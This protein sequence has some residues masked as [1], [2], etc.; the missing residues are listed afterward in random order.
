MKFL[1][2]T[3]LQHFYDKYLRPLKD[4]AFKNTANNLT[5]ETEGSVLDARQGKV[6]NDLKLSIAKVINNLLTTEAGFALDARQ[7]KVLDDKITELN[8]NKIDTYNISINTGE[9]LTGETFVGRP[10]YEKLVDIGALPNKTQKTVP[11]GISNAH[12]FWIDPTYSMIFNTAASYPMPYNDPQVAS[13][14]VTA[15]IVGSGTSV[16]VHT[17]ADW[18]TYS[19]YV[20][21][22][23]TKK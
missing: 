18:S 7:G 8:G 11:T 12:Y 3:G 23:Y 6:L 5:T 1:D 22:K 10:V 14:G 20:A 19:A 13:N 2:L 4:A 16:I 21:V 15:R 9:F 17:A